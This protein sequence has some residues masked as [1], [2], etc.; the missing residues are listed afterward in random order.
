MSKYSFG[1]LKIFFENE[2]F[3]IQTLEV[4]PECDPSLDNAIL[5]SI[6][7]DKGWFGNAFHNGDEPIGSDLSLVQAFSNDGR[8]HV[9][10]T[11]EE[12]LNWLISENYADEVR[13]FVKMTENQT[14]SISIEVT[15]QNQIIASKYWEYRQ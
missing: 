6:L 1:D 11:I 10:K 13:V 12:A 4:S 8:K 7:T 3:D 2:L 14:Y 5:L 9:E 15:K